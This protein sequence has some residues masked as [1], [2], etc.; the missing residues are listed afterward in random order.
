[1]SLRILSRSGGAEAVVVVVV[2]YKHLSGWL[3][4]LTMR[5]VESITESCLV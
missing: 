2:E 3:E 5:V 1:M 4:S